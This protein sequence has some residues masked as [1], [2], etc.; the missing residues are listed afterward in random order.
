MG[1]Y[2]DW[3]E[4]TDQALEDLLKSPACLVVLAIE[5]L[6]FLILCGWAIEHG[7]KVLFGW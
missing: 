4:V 3:N 6:A 5:G 7:L 2:E 1:F